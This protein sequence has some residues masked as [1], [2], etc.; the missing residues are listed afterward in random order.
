MTT[1]STRGKCWAEHS[2]QRRDQPPRSISVEAPQLAQ[3]RCREC[4]QARLRAA[5]K[6]GASSRQAPPIVSNAARAFACGCS[7]AENRGWPSWMPRNRSVAEAWLPFEPPVLSDCGKAVA[8]D[9]LASAGRRSARQ[10]GAGRRV[11]GRRG[12]F[13]GPEKKGSGR[14]RAPRRQDRF[15]RSPVE[16]RQASFAETVERL[17]PALANGSCGADTTLSSS[18]K[19]VNTCVT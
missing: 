3:K 11:P 19:C 5:A 7:V 12:R 1:G 17:P 8:P 9:E 2:G 16:G 13:P 4:H 14:K 10:G 6:S 15:D 18:R